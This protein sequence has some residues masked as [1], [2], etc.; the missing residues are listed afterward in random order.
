M[1]QKGMEQ[2]EEIKLRSM[3]YKSRFLLLFI[4]IVLNLAV[5]PFLE[6]ALGVQFL[7]GIFFSF[8]LLSCIYSVI[9]T[10]RAFWVSLIL[11][12]PSFCSIWLG[13]LLGNSSWE[14]AGA[15]LQVIFWAYILV[16]I[17]SHLLRAMEVTA[18]TIMGAACCYFLIGLAWSFIFLALEFSFPGAFSTPRASADFNVFI[19]FSFVTLTTLGF[20]DITPV[21]NPARSLTILEAVIGQ[22]FVAITISILVGSYL[23]TAAKGIGHGERNQK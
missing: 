20:G 5:R 1:N 4:G 14:I 23:S 10:R 9:R 18:D 17:L 8:I 12:I 16:V 21:S 22:L 15:I 19:Y 2:A 13:I 7:S 3:I 6:G 11:G